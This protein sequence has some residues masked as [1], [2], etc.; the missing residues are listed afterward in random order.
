MPKTIEALY[1]WTEVDPSGSEGTIAAM[2][3]ALP[4]LG[5]VPLVTRKREIAEGPMRV[6]AV[7]HRRA[8]GHTVRLVRWTAREDLEELP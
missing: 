2:V 4:Y 6:A 3:P 8:S 1:T 7:G 5:V